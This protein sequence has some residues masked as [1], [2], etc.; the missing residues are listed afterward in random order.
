MGIDVRPELLETS[1]IQWDGRQHGKR[2]LQQMIM[3]MK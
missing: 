3:E 2:D 1:F